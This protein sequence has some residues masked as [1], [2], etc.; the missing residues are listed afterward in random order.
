MSAKEFVSMG[1]GEM[2]RIKKGTRHP[3]IDGMQWCS[4]CQ[5]YKNTNEFYQDKSRYNGVTVICKS[6]RGSYQREYL[7]NYYLRYRA[8]LLPKHRITALRAIEWRKTAEFVDE[9]NI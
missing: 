6:C 3:R 2:R 8:E 5:C 7:H 4:C 1:E 9:K